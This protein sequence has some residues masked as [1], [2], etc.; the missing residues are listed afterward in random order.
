MSAPVPFAKAHGLGNDF[1]LIDA[2]HCPREASPFVRRLC[3]RHL[4]IGAD[5]VLVYTL[6]AA[7]GAVGMRLVNADGGDAEI[8]GNGVRCLAAYAVFKGWMRPRHVVET[9]AGPRD[10]GV[11]AVGGTRFRV[12]TDLGPAILESRAI[13][14]ALDPPPRGWWTTGCRRRDKP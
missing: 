13:P 1:I 4:G 9:A 8:S 10:V 12:A 7:A 5:G 11:E 3:D 14:V 6:K 2:R